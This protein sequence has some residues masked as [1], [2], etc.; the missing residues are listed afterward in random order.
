MPAGRRI[1]SAVMR[2]FLTAAVA[3]CACAAAPSAAAADSGGTGIIVRY[4]TGVTAPERADVLADAGAEKDR[5]LR[6]SSTD[7]VSVPAG[8][9]G[10][11][12]A[13]LRA[14]PDVRWAMIDAPV[15]AASSDPGFGSQW[16]LSNTGQSGG[17][18]NADMNFPEAWAAGYQGAGAAV[19]IVDTGADL[20]H[21]DLA[22]AFWTNPGETGA[23]KESN[24][25]DDDH[26]G[27]VDDWRG[28]DFYSRDKTPQD[29][30]GHGTHVAGIIAA[31]AGNGIAV[32]GGAPQA[33]I[34]PVRAL[35]ANGSGSWSQVADAF[36]YAGDLGAKVVNASLGSIGDIPAI[37]DVIA[38]HPNTLYVVAAGNDGLNLSTVTEM[39][40]EAPS[41]NVLCVGAST[42]T[43]AR[44]SFSN[45]G[46]SVAVS[47][48]GESILS[49]WLGGGTATASG[50]SMASPYAA[51]EAAL[52]AGAGA[53]SPAAIKSLMLSTADAKPG[54]ASA[55]ASGARLNAQ[56]AAA[57]SAGAPDGDSDGV[58][59]PADN[60]P[61]V[62]NSGQQDAD[63]DGIGDACDP[64]PNG[65]DSDSDGVPDS[66]DNC[67]GAANPS[68]SDRDRDGTGDAC[69][70]T[71]DGPDA[72]RDGI[73]DRLDS[74]PSAP[75]PASNHGCPV[76]ALPRIVSMTVS[77]SGARLLIAAAPSAAATVTVRLEQQSCQAG[78][79]AWKLKGQGSASAGAS[80]TVTF[81]Y[82]ASAGSWRATATA[83]NAAGA[84]PARQASFTLVRSSRLTSKIRALSVLPARRR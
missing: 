48:P 63:H 8:D 66:A 52:L 81:S 14:D 42:R 47:A 22:G 49:L 19:A 29:E 51:A 82:P 27:L 55:S 69:D 80:R 31:R 56:R 50:T 70:P 57:A 6:L 79:C 3:A 32:A 71:P 10:P 74:C 58:A 43:D 7:L 23:G 64:A 46:S 25:I 68:Q 53:A 21:P 36:D 17:T 44:A 30:N 11:A 84:G 9:A 45:Y 37:R 54:L 73:P 1:R 35:G 72:D 24:G 34:I 16:A 13:D 75:G 38:S 5:S 2:R 15:H 62:P 28:W 41:A 39:P 78:A 67:P 20:S 61:A 65:P 18:V 26:N 77:T 83:S 40:C 4:G 12:L 60:C 76:P 59:D 33:K